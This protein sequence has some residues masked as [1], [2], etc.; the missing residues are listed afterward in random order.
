MIWCTHTHRID[1]VSQ[2]RFSNRKIKQTVKDSN[3]NDNIIAAIKDKY[4]QFFAKTFIT[5]IGFCLKWN[6]SLPYQTLLIINEL[7]SM[8]A[9]LKRNICKGLKFCNF[10]LTQKSFHFKAWIAPPPYACLLLY[11]YKHDLLIVTVGPCEKYK[12]YSK[13]NKTISFTLSYVPFLMQWKAK[14]LIFGG[15]FCQCIN[16]NNEKNGWNTSHRDQL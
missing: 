15:F 16:W 4:T 1:R 5:D 2:E 3:Q 10:K 8:Y 6:I 9:I 13:D 14:I 11:I 7:L 12:I